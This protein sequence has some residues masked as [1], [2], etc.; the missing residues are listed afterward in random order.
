MK[1]KNKW[2]SKNIV[3]KTFPIQAINIFLFLKCELKEFL[4][5]NMN[6]QD[7]SF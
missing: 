6:R 3:S 5:S 2:K 7:N 4:S 1:I